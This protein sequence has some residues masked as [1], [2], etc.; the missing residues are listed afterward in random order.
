M[1]IETDE[2][3]NCFVDVSN[4]RI[5]WVQAET[6]DPGTDWASGDV[7][8]IQVYNNGTD[9]RLRGL[10]PE[11]ALSPDTSTGVLQ[12]VAAT[13]ELWNEV[14]QKEAPKHA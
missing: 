9:G 10:G 2:R 14:R 12:F 3:G 8:R 11:I 13:T 6:R 4:V 1:K 7:L 5:T